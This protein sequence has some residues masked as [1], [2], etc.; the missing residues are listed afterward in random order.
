MNMLMRLLLLVGVLAILLSS[1]RPPQVPSP[2]STPT[3]ASATPTAPPTRTASPT[4]T[5][6]QTPTVTFTPT[7]LGPVGEFWITVGPQIVVYYERTEWEEQTVP[8]N[9][10]IAFLVHRSLPNCQIMRL[11][12]MGMMEMDYTTTIGDFTWSVMGDNYF[13]TFY[14]HSGTYPRYRGGVRIEGNTACFRAA[15]RLLAK[16]QSGKEYAQAGQCELAPPPKLK[17]GDQADILVGTYLRSEPRWSNETRIRILNKQDGPVTIIGGPV[18]GLYK[19]GEYVYW[20][21][22]LPN[23]E[24]GWMAEGDFTQTYLSKR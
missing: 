21:V 5:S 11:P 15:M 7:P 2:A 6:T 22:Q 24:Q 13:P 1:C 12:P 3:L 9:D 14:L 18:C 8:E 17:V 4:A 16:I 10:L 23:G 19:N 20:Q